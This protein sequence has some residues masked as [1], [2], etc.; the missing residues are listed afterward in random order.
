MTLQATA[1]AEFFRHTRHTWVDDDNGWEECESADDRGAV[2]QCGKNCLSD[3]PPTPT[4]PTRGR[5]KERAAINVNA[6][7]Y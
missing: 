3:Q 5:E 4:L 6:D 1:G 7:W 2:C